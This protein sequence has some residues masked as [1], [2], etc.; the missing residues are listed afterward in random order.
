VTSSPSST[1]STA[2]NRRAALSVTA[3]R[4]API[5]AG[6]SFLGWTSGA[7]DG[8]DYCVRQLWDMKGKIDTQVMNEESLTLFAGL[9]GWALARVHAR[10]GDPAAIHG[11]IGSGSAFDRGFHRVR[12]R[13]RRPDGAGSSTAARAVEAGDLPGTTST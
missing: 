8:V 1:N 6:D 5:G 11:Y 13:L 4:T 2:G 3:S 7:V 12:G 10:S 9:C